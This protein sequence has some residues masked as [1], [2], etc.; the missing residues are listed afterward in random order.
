MAFGIAGNAQAMS[1]SEALSRAMTHDPS[2]LAAIKSRDAGVEKKFQGI[3]GVLPTVVG[4]YDDGRSYRTKTNNAAWVKSTIDNRS[5][6]ITA[7]QPIFDLAAIRAAQQGFQSAAG[8]EAG[9][10][11]ARQEAMLRLV[12]AYFEVLNSQDA[13]ATTL[14]EK[15]AIGEQL[16]AAK[17]SFEVGTATVTD[18]QEAQARFDLITASEIRARN[19]LN[20]KRQ[21]LSILTGQPT[22]EALPGFKAGVSIPSPMPMVADEWVNQARESGFE[23]RKAFADAERNRMELT[24]QVFNNLPTVDVVARRTWAK[25]TPT[26]SGEFETDYVGLNVTVP[27]F[28]GGLN[29]SQIREAAATRDEF[30]HRLQAARLNAEQGAREAYLN[31][32]AG[33]AQITAL[34][35][36]EKSSRLA[37]ESN[38]LGYQVGVRINIDVLNAQQQLFAAQRDLSK[39]RTDTLLAGLRLKAAVAALN[40]DDVDV[41]SGLILGQA[42]KKN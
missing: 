11:V 33:L 23:V 31:V 28:A 8:A 13:L 38:Q 18:Q 30:Q 1:L 36:A 3:A 5:Y 14:A 42:P 17:R 19:T 32:V 9:F 12:S 7:T 25:E 10:G 37:L 22:P 29:I 35:A 24:K 34:E 16:E 41:V 21:A 20:I 15:K 4:A 40:P 2:Y 27:I 39:A 26:V 6:S